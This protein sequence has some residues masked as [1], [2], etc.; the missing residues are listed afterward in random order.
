M[1]RTTLS[2]A[3]SRKRRLL[4]T[5]LAIVLGVAFL[6]AT[7][8]L[9]DS[10][11]AGFEVAFS[12]AN[13]GTDAL[14]RSGSELTGGE[15]SVRPPIDA[16]L[17][18]RVAAVDGVADVVATIEGTGQVLDADG[19][20][21]GGNGPPTV[22]AG[23]I[24]DPARTGW[25]LAEGRAPETPGEVVI[26]RATA[27]DA[28][29]AVGDTVDVLVPDAVQ[30]TVVG[31][32]T[33]G[34]DDSIGGTTYV[35]FT[36]AEAQQLL[37]GSK[38]LISGIVVAADEG[39][40][41]EELV[42]RLDTVLPGG[43]EAITGADLTDEMQADIEGDFLGF[44]TTALLV[45]ACVALLVAAFSIF[46]TFSILVA[47]RTR[48]SALL[49]ALGA[50]R[51]QVLGSA[52][53]ESALV[54][55]VG[56]VVGA[57]TGLLVASGLLALMESA[58]FGLPTD[59][60]EVSAGSLVTAVIVG[61]VVTMVGGVV[62]AWRSSRVAPL[63]ALR[64]VEV[65]TAASSK[66]RALIG[67]VVAVT[68]ATVLLVS[69]DALTRAGLGAVVLVIGVLLLGPV[70]AR[71]VGNLLGAPLGLRGVSGDLARR[72]AVRNPKRTSSTAAALLVGVGVV[73]LFT[74]FG[75]SV[76]QSIEDTVDQTFGGELA[77]TPAG[78]GF[79]GA[80][81]STGLVEDLDQLPEVEV[82]A[83]LGFGAAKV[84][85]RQDGVGFA[86][87]QAISRVA[88]FYVQSGDIGAVGDDDLAMSADYA[89][90][91]GYALGDEVEVGFADG[92]TDTF[93][94]AATY[95]DR[96][97]GGDVL[98]PQAPWVEHNPQASFFLV[99][100]DLPDEV[101]LDEGRAAVEALTEARGGP[102]AMD[103]QEFVE[104]Q[105]A[106]IDV[107]LTI[108]YALL[109]VA[110]LIAL[111]GI[112]NT[113]SLSVHERTRELGLLRA[114]GQSRSQLRAM[115]RWESVIVATF[116]SMGGMGLGL[117]LAWG[118]VRALNASEGFGTFVAPVGSL[119]TVLLVGAAVG[120]V[121]G[122]RPA[123]R[124]SRLDVLAA[125]AAD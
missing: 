13:A 38:D 28:E 6:S 45:F 92:A 125:V 3:W 43:T 58:G 81:L 10:A 112:A 24:D 44:L 51:R 59:G 30:V 57:G 23:W 42:A 21:I 62:P 74:V 50:S 70:V 66:L 119:A 16:A 120:V 89:A 78:A 105:A 26:D 116:G 87:P 48:E 94:L 22:A 40:S 63:A 53:A 36:A 60:L 111:M 107:L 41:Q 100:V 73:S 1:L 37:L 39:V 79:S 85:G 95:D 56:A 64:E 19:D 115:V 14:V 93:T 52:L 5:A 102:D 32:A 71:P 103:R 68:G 110:I 124:A 90:E 91:H 67:V 65:D 61:L 11:K 113:L 35:A 75:A 101:S 76:S 109:A 27:T 88:D 106:E 55:L 49:R 118:L 98:L 46:N 99:M 117:F 2:A 4:G 83:G 7:L 54:G 104:S 114:V 31:I 47:Q 69:S 8:V 15:Q 123:W 108:I 34:D 121:A 25:D 86:D 122:L 17:L 97:M 33:F 82:A 96:A 72:N 77:L 29:V 84:D 18:D 12:E 80:G 9:G 20:P